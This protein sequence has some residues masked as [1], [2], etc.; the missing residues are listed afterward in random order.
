MN[1]K[2]RWKVNKVTWVTITNNKTAQA[3]IILY[4]ETE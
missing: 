2:C 3:Q 4:D 1:K